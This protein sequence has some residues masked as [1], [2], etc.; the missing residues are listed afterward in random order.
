MAVAFLGGLKDNQSVLRTLVTIGSL[1]HD[2]EAKGREE[3][4]KLV[5]NPL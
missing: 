2:M 3:A 1:V 4:E 5:T